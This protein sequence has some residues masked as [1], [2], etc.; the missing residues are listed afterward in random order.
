MILVH[1]LWD[2]IHLGLLHQVLLKEQ[3]DGRPEPTVQ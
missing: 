2:D 1:L 3:G